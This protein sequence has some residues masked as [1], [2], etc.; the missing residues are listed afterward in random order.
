MPLLLLE[1]QEGSLEGGRIGGC[2]LLSLPQPAWPENHLACWLPP[3][4]A[5]SLPRE[6]PHHLTPWLP[7]TGAVILPSWFPGRQIG[8]SITNVS[9]LSP[10][11]LPHSHIS[12]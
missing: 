12:P 6:G 8:Q 3:T 4:A 5:T 11:S 7:G 1:G 2:R 9:P 10:F